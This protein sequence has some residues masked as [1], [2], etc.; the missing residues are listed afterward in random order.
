M[1]LRWETDD[2]LLKKKIRKAVAFESNV[3]GALLRATIDGLGI[4]FLPEAYLEHEITSHEPKKGALVISRE[5]LW[6]HRIFLSARNR[7]SR[8]ESPAMLAALAHELAISVGHR[9]EA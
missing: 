8:E 2:Y 5:P 1:R 9:S 3:V 7:A 6:N 4:G